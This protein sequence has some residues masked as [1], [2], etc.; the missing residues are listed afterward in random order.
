M[1]RNKVNLETIKISFFFKVYTIRICYK[2]YVKFC[3]LFS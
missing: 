1:T 3:V 2:F